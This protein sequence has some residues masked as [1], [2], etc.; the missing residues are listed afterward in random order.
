MTFLFIRT[1]KDRIILK[2]DFI[3]YLIK[4]KTILK[5]VYFG[6]IRFYGNFKKK[7]IYIYIYYKKMLKFNSP[8][9]QIPKEMLL[10]NKNGQKVYNTLKKNGGLTS[11][12]N[13]KSINIISVPGN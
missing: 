7:Y 12:K 6:V 3:N 13:K 8:I 11:V 9:I 1:L 10:K 2:K 4:I 5:V